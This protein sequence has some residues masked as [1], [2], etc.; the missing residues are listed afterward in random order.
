MSPSP[1]P[2]DEGIS[3]RDAITDLENGKTR[4]EVIRSRVADTLQPPKSPQNSEL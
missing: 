2:E 4:R 3:L 1:H